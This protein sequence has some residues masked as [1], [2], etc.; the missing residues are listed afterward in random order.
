[1]PGTMTDG[2]GAR[3]G[4]RQIESGPAGAGIPWEGAHTGGKA[5]KEEEEVMAR[6]GRC[7]GDKSFMGSK[8]SLRSDN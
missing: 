5:N 2:T 8:V 1:M 4:T 3:L 7:Q 6:H